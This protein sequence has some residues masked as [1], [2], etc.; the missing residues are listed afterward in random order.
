MALPAAVAKALLEI[1]PG[2][3]WT[4][5]SDG[6]DG[7][8][9][10]NGMAFVNRE[11]YIITEVAHANSNDFVTIPYDFDVADNVYE[12]HPEDDEDEVAYFY[13]RT[14]ADAQD[15]AETHFDGRPR[16]SSSRRFTTRF[17][18]RAGGEEEKAQALRGRRRPVRQA[19]RPIQDGPGHLR[20]LDFAARRERRAHAGATHDGSNKAQINR[21]SSQFI[22]V[23]TAQSAFRNKLGIAGAT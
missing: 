10:T 23:F 4:L 2:R 12:V 11:G 3:V 13:E 19:N 5:V 15:A 14:K 20:S 17:A 6:Y 22:I 16:H 9:I 7:R 1:E 21:H 18:H 8:V